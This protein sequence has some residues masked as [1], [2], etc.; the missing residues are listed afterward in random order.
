MFDAHARNIIESIAALSTMDRTDV[1]RLLSTAYVEIIRSRGEATAA[2]G[3]S[4]DSIVADLRRLASAL[5]SAAVFDDSLPN[6]PN[7]VASAASA[8]VAAEALALAVDLQESPSNSEDAQAIAAYDRVEAGLLYLIGGYDINAV[9]IARPALDL[10]SESDSITA[11]LRAI[12][13]FCC[14]D[15]SQPYAAPEDDAGQDAVASTRRAV[16]AE[17]ITALD[18]FRAWLVGD[19]DDSEAAID[20][21][22]RLCDLLRTSSTGR[23][24]PDLADLYHITSLLHAALRRTSARALVARVPVPD[25]PAEHV[26]QFLDYRKRRAAGDAGAGLR[27]RPFLWPSTLEFVEQCLPGPHRDAVVTMPTGSGKSFLAEL[28]VVHALSRGWV[29]Y[30]TPT[31]ALAHQVRRDLRDALHPFTDVKV[32]AFVGGSE[33]S[34][35]VDQPE[36]SGDEP[37]VA[38]M[39]PEKAALAI[40]S[41]PAL[42]D[43]CALCVF[44][45]CHLLNDR[46]GRGALA[47]LVLAHLFSV[48]P[49]ARVLLQSAMVANGKEL[50]EWIADATGRSAAPSQIRWRP[51]RTARGFVVVDRSEYEQAKTDSETPPAGRGPFR[52]SATL[53]LIVGLSGPWTLD[54]PEDYRML[55]LPLNVA[56]RRSRK[57]GGGMGP[58]GLEDSSWKNGTGARLSSW[59]AAAGLP[60]INFILSSKHHAFSAAS[61]VPGT[62]PGAIT[63]GP[64]PEVVEAWLRLA[65]AEFGV[66]SALRDLYRRGIAVHTAALLQVEQAASEYMFTRRHTPLIFATGTLAQGLNL[67][68]NAVVVSGSKVGDPRDLDAASGLV[69]ANELILNGFGRAG[70]PGF[71]NQSLVVLVSDDYY[72]GSLTA[73]SDP[74]AVL[75]EPEYKVLEEEDASVTVT[76]SL[77]PLLNDILASGP[78]PEALAEGG[79]ALLSYLSETGGHELGAILR[80]TFGGYR[81]RVEIDRVGLDVVTARVETV[82]SLFLEQDGVPP[83]LATAAGVAGVGFHRALRL[84]QAISRTPSVLAA[85]Y[86]TRTVFEW[87]TVLVDVLSVLTPR[88]AEQYGGDAKSDEVR[89]TLRTIKQSL[90]DR[91]DDPEWTPSPEWRKSWKA[92]EQLAQDYMAGATYRDFG[93]KYLNIPQDEITSER[94]SGRLPQLLKVVSEVIEW[95]LAIDAGCMV[96]LIEAHLRASDPDATVPRPLAILPLGLRYGCGSDDVLAWF[97]YGYR[98]R[99]A[100]HALARHFPLAVPTDDEEALREAVHAKRREWLADDDDL[101]DDTLRAA[102]VVIQSGSEL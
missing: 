100:A 60:T 59:L 66:E 30:L 58:F 78:P 90:G 20:R 27:P 61:R 36:F 4:Q 81:K 31:N 63:A 87:L 53:G 24:V 73:S 41:T 26:Q 75:K 57:R 68:S 35:T 19:S 6:P 28:A 88:Y 1:R 97:R 37:F 23:L 54:G 96:A 9:A 77:E 25:G 92:I 62:L 47:E 91:D 14:G 7:E 40:R 8:F 67:P 39:T 102:R 49:E 13:R 94:G 33:Y 32:A 52:G 79:F 42:F 46:S 34:T 99:A 83:W 76:S 64:F 70:R 98:Q 71:S 74:R 10:A 84:W 43:R 29:L 56:L 17:G 5:E 3:R 38:V 95:G 48:A 82:R 93:A 15:V 12:A 2:D 101:D 80:R 50:A 21:M 22:S 86:A 69:R 55:R 11:L 89:L 18:A 51:S 45:E 65:Q 44:D 72:I 85:G 16:A